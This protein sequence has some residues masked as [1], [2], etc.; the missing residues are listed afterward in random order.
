M[1]LKPNE[2]TPRAPV[3]ALR[4]SCVGSASRSHNEPSRALTKGFNSRRCALPHARCTH[5][6]R[7]ACSMPCRPEAASEWP[8]FA[9]PPPAVAACASRR[10]AAHDGTRARTRIRSWLSAPA[11]AALLYALACCAT[12]QRPAIVK[13]IATAPRH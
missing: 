4:T 9:L 6:D 8:T 7:V 2:L 13:D 11:L 12:R 1:P 3:H 5:N 10:S